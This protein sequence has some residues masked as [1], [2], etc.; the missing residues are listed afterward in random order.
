[1]AAEATGA[2]HPRKGV[3]PGPLAGRA[4]LWINMLDAVPTFAGQAL[5]I[6]P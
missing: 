2:S 5:P 4:V 6:R 3:L 1:M